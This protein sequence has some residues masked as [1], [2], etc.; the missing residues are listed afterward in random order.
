L[1]KEKGNIDGE[2]EMVVFK[3]GEKNPTARFM[4]YWGNERSIK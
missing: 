3:E 2:E 1:T 4:D